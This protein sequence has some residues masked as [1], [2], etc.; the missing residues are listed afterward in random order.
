M[1]AHTSHLPQEVTQPD[2]QS[3]PLPLPGKGRDKDVPGF[4]CELKLLSDKIHKV[5]VEFYKQLYE[6][7]RSTYKCS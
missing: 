2:C 6:S 5:Q 3:Q 4:P 1:F 7:S